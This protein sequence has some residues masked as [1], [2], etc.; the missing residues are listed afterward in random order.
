VSTDADCELCYV[1]NGA[2]EDRDGRAPFKFHTDGVRMRVVTML[3][4]QMGIR[5]PDWLSQIECKRHEARA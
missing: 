4:R 1:L 3:E 5:Q 2:L